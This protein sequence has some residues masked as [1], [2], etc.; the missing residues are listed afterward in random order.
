VPTITSAQAKLEREVLSDA[1]M[2]SL[3]S[4]ARARLSKQLCDLS[5]VSLR[6]SDGET[7]LI[8]AD[9]R[10]ATRPSFAA[11]VSGRELLVAV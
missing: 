3:V 7:P 8:E 6:G 2:F 10:F 5:G 11:P 1:L 9:D 4:T